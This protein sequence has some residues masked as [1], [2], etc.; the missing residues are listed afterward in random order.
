MPR[1][2]VFGVRSGGVSL[3][4]GVLSLT[5]PSGCVDGQRGIFGRNFTHG[6]ETDCVCL[7]ARSLTVHYRQPKTLFTALIQRALGLQT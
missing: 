4:Q 3:G 5:P 7:I 6:R 1:G 2:G